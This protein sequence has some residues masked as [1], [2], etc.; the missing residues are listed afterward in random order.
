MSSNTN[1][2]IGKSTSGGTPSKNASR[3]GYLKKDIPPQ[4]LI[5]IRIERPINATGYQKVL[6]NKVFRNIVMIYAPVKDKINLRLESTWSSL[7]DSSGQAGK[8]GALF[9]VAGRSLA[10]Q[11]ISRRMWTGTAPLDFTISMEFRA[12]RNP[13]QEVVQPCMELQK[14]VLPYEGA[15]AGKRFSKLFLSSPGPNPFKELTDATGLDAGEDITV[16]YGSL[17][18]FKRVIVKDVEIEYSN[19]FTREGLPISANATIHFQT[20]E[21]LTKESLG[22]SSRRDSIYNKQI[23]KQK[24]PSENE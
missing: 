7:V 6:D 3:L 21:I 2:K 19:Q 17:L 22:S 18:R 24:D 15:G 14:L 13:K 16:S 8:I 11:Y 4:Y 9:Q 1:S 23:Y 5:G 12:D 10:N 20:Y